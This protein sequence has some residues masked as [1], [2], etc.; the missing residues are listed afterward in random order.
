MINQNKHI[1]LSE[2]ALQLIDEIEK[3]SLAQIE[4]MREEKLVLIS[5][6]NEEIRRHNLEKNKNTELL[7]QLDYYRKNQGGGAS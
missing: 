1:S 5:Q 4:K 6:L 2:E 7:H 3:R